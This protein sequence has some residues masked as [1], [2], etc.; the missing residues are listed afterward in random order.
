MTRTALP[1]TTVPAA[2][3]RLST[4]GMALSVALQP[5]VYYIVFL[6]HHRVALQGI[7][8][9]FTERNVLHFTTFLL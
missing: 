1:I 2:R 6:F 9:Y 3:L 8:V 4:L 5:L 7:N